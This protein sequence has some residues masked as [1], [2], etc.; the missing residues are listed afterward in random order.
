MPASI[1]ARQKIKNASVRWACLALGLA[2]GLDAIADGLDSGE[3]SASAG[4]GFEEKPGAGR[5]DSGAGM[6]GTHDRGRMATAPDGFRDAD[7]KRDKHANQEE[8][9][10]GDENRAGLAQT[11]QIDYGQ[12]QQRDQAKRE[13][14]WMQRGNGRGEGS[15]SGRDPNGSIERV[16]DQQRSSGEHAGKGPRLSFATMYDPPP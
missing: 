1:R 13:S 4:E 11:A 14:T 8:I 9:G 12:N 2:K 3:S 15:N 7:A 5:G 6:R 16:I 10:R